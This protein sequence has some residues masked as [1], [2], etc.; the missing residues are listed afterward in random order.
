MRLAVTRASSAWMER[1]G[2]TMDGVGAEKALVEAL[3]SARREDLP[4]RPPVW[5]TAL[6][7]LARR[8]IRGS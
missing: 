8:F 6:E 7:T 4:G 2:T 5:R 1:I 3:L